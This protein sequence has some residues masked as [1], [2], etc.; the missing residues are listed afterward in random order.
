MSSANPLLPGHCLGVAGLLTILLHRQT[1][2]EPENR[3]GIS[4]MALLMMMTGLRSDAHA[5]KARRWASKG[6]V[7]PP[8]KGS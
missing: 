8:A 4:M 7:P 1:G 6:I 3:E 5:L 2:A